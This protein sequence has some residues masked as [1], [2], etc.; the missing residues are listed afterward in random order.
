MMS[1]VTICKVPF[2]NLIQFA[3]GHGVQIFHEES[4]RGSELGLD[5]LRYESACIYGH[6]IWA[7]Y[8]LYLILYSFTNPHIYG[9]REHYIGTVYRQV[10]RVVCKC[11]VV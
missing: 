4:L 2:S 6:L 10:D 3:V 9:G 5:A 11:D 8:R 1:L 7:K